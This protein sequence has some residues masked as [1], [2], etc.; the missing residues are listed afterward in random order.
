MEGLAHMHLGFWGHRMGTIQDA[1]NSNRISI[2]GNKDWV[3]GKAKRFQNKV[4]D[5][6]VKFVEGIKAFTQPQSTR[7]VR[8]EA[9][10]GLRDE[11]VKIHWSFHLDG[12][13]VDCTS[14]SV[15]RTTK[16]KRKA[17][18]ELTSKPT[19]HWAT[20]H[21]FCKRE[22]PLLQLLKPAADIC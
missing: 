17:S 10:L 11:N 15:L 6:L 4:E 2:Y 5:D 20:F 8:K 3:L 18:G 22:Y 14:N 16:T 7:F 1:F 19:C 21:W 9:C 12:Q 13:S